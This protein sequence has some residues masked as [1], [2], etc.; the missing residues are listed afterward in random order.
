[1]DFAIVPATQADV[2]VIQAIHDESIAALPRPEFFFA[3]DEAFFVQHI[4]EDGFTLLAKTNGETAGFLLVDI[5]AMD[6]RNLGRDAG[7]GGADLMQC[8]HM[9]TACVRPAYRGHGLQ[10]R[11]MLAAEARLR[12]Q[13]FAYAFATVH[14]DNAAS[15]RSM[16][17]IGYSIVATKPKYG[18]LL[19]HI[20]CKHIAQE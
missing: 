13:G 10:K 12:D 8:A 1:M 9:D 7:F 4:A 15:L 14:P 17:S 16:V 20:M 6:E 18:G 2:P 5:P 11:L 19:R 3:S